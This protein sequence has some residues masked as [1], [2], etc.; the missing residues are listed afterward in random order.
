[1]ASIEKRVRDGRTVWV[2]RWRD[3]DGR[4]RQQTCAKRS[5]ADR[6][7]TTVAADVLRG[8]YLDPDA[9]RVTVREYAERWLAAQ[10]FDPSTR[11]QVSLR[12]RLHVFPQLG[13][14]RV[15]SVRPSTVQAWLRG[16]DQLAP[17]TVRTIYQHLSGIFS[18]AVDDGLVR[19]NPCRAASVLRG[20]VRLRCRPSRSRHRAT[21]TVRPSRTRFSTLA[22]GQSP[23]LCA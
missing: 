4:Q 5:E 19:A 13:S 9:G 22:T 20:N 16:L 11:E 23:S 18:A 21:H 2:A 15:G 17:S 6:L 7:V 12:L 1:M 10:T 14:H 3:P 8:D